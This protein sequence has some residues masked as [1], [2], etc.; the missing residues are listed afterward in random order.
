MDNGHRGSSTAFLKKAANSHIAAE[1]IGQ[2]KDIKKL[3][4]SLTYFENVKIANAFAWGINK[5]IEKG[6][7]G[8]LKYLLLMVNARVSVKGYRSGQLVDVL[9]EMQRVAGD[10][11]D[12]NSKGKKKQEENV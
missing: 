4:L 8:K 9:T 7:D 10:R 11:M 1:L 2:D 3:F 6:I 5:C 12:G